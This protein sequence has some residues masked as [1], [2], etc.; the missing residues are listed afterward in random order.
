MTITHR[1]HRLEGEPAHAHSGDVETP[2]ACVFASPGVQ[3]PDESVDGVLGLRPASRVPAGQ[4]N[5][6]RV[7]HSS[8]AGS[9]VRLR[10]S[11]L[12]RPRGH[13]EDGRA[14]LG[15]RDG[16]GV[17]DTRSQALRLGTEPPSRPRCR[18]AD[19]QHARRCAP[20][21]AGRDLE[22]LL[23]TMRT[24]L[25]ELAAARDARWRAA[26]RDRI[27]GSRRSA[28]SCARASGQRR[29]ATS[30]SSMRRWA[31]TLRG[32][33]RY[34]SD[35]SGRICSCRPAAA[36]AATWRIQA[37]AAMSSRFASRVA[38]IAASESGGGACSRIDST[39][40]SLRRS[41]ATIGDLGGAGAVGVAGRVLQRG[42]VVARS[43]APRA[44]AR[45]PASPHR[46]PRR[47]SA[48]P[49]EPLGRAA[50]VAVAEIVADRGDRS[51]A[52]RAVVQ[53]PR[54][55]AARR[56]AA[57]PRC[58]TRAPHAGSTSRKVRDDAAELVDGRGTAAARTGTTTPPGASRS[59]RV[60]GRTR[61]C[62]TTRRRGGTAGPARARSRRSVV[63]VRE[64]VAAV[65]AHQAHARIVASSGRR[66]GARISSNT[67]GSM[68]TTSSR[69]IG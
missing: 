45:R 38:R 52:T 55:V 1:D 3:P 65:V 56:S 67:A 64:M 69:S 39:G 62:R 17:G 54:S 10:L 36:R 26:R 25:I 68:S 22:Q 14:P 41:S 5:P 37:L 53:E 50:P 15:P 23:R 4:R 13:G 57:A 49:V 48:W 21:I 60:R 27:S 8:S 47:G 66:S 31:W 16:A 20:G 35:R 30:A 29:N 6:E 24:R 58:C 2:A 40:S 42:P 34:A 28:V 46:K 9:H 43:G 32:L 33:N 11:P 51:R 44:S 7:R 19:Q 63:G 59:R 18:G 12:G 61:R